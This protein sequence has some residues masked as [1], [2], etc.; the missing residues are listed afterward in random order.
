MTDETE[1]ALKQLLAE[2]SA[3]P[4]GDPEPVVTLSRRYRHRQATRVATST[5][6]TAIAVVA[7]VVV[8]QL[9][10]RGG[11]RD[12]PAVTPTGRRAAATAPPRPAASMAARRLVGTSDAMS[13]DVRF[14]ETNVEFRRA[15][16]MDDETA[17]VGCAADGRGSNYDAKVR[18]ANF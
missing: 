13:P 1:R 12:T 4:K 17:A 15:V 2:R 6:A 8:P 5:G 9:V 14:L 18:T 7:L 16:L 3:V 11:T 10:D